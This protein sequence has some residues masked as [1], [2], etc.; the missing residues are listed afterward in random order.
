MLSGGVDDCGGGG[1]EVG[2]V[3]LVHRR[4]VVVRRVDFVQRTV[5]LVQRR[6][7]L[8]QRRIGFVQRRIGFVQRRI[9][10][11]QR[12]VGFNSVQRRR[13]ERPAGLPRGPI[14]HG[15]GRQGC[16]GGV[17]VDVELGLAVGEVEGNYSWGVGIFLFVR[18][19]HRS[20][21]GFGDLFRRPVER[22]VQGFVEGIILRSLQRRID[23]GVVS[24]DERVSARFVFD[25]SVFLHYIIHALK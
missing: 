22:I 12:I 10:F 18:G 24:L 8:V 3:H 14:S 2:G 11:V 17:F 23:G 5:R 9:G 4:G 21:V 20:L 6:I 7:G 1:V 19:F 16:S 15:G 13:K 25:G